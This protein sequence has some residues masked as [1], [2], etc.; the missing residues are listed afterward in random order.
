MKGVRF[1]VSMKFRK[2]DLQMHSVYSHDGI[3]QPETIVARAKK[4]GL[5][6][7]AI[8]DHNTVRGGLEAKKYESD[9]FEVVVGSE[10]L[11]NK[12]EVIGL[13]L[14]KEIEE[15]DFSKVVREIKKQGGLVLVPHP[16]DRLRRHVL[17]IPLKD[18]KFIDCFEC[19][20]ARAV[21]KEDNFKAQRFAQLHGLAQTGG[22][23]AHLLNEIG[24]G[25]TL[26]RGS[27]RRALLRGETRWA[28]RR[29]SFLFNH[30][31]TKLVKWKGKFFS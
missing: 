20:N 23:D 11:T 21:F 28:G 3:M 13:F 4:I 6:G 31:F 30:G 19:Y 9:D 5:D 2:Y 26:C 24:N 16:F 10:I 8:T 15:R 29:K 17:K 25:L 14:K 7:V 1:R 27:L 12:G 22:S 18:L